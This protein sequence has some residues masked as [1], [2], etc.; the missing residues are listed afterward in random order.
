MVDV[1][2]VD[3]AVEVPPCVTPTSV[4]S[5]PVVLTVDSPTMAVE[6]AAAVAAVV[7]SVA[8]VVVSEATVEEEEE[9]EVVSVM[10]KYMDCW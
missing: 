8:A 5:A 10:R 7:V 2:V 1:A 9:E 3:V 4:A 6:E